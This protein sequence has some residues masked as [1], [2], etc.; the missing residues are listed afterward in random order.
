[1]PLPFHVK[2]NGVEAVAGGGD[3]DGDDDGKGGGGEELIGKLPR[4]LGFD[5]VFKTI[6]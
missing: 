3:G 6:A 1:V 5:A 2:L 4:M